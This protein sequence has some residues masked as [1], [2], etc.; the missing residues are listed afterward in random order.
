[1][2]SFIK[3]E[4][5]EFGEN[6]VVI[7][8]GGIGYELTV[9]NVTVEKIKNGSRFVC[10]QCYMAVREDGISLY[11]FLTKEEKNMFLKLITISGVGPK[12]AI[13]IL[14]GMEV[15]DLMRVIMASDIKALSK[16]KGV[17]KKTAERIVLELRGEIDAESR[18]IMESAKAV[19][20][21]E[22]LDAD[23][24]DAISALRSLGFTQT[25]AAEAVK[26]AKPFAKT[27]EELVAKALRSL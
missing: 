10:L 15:Y 17:G 16:L 14:S 9:S 7:D 19:G 13:G 26:K 4:A 25:E 6:T 18:E 1:M 12:A 3:G 24:A 11:G 27:A 20:E 23:S 22:T 2:L 5:V 21:E 8:N